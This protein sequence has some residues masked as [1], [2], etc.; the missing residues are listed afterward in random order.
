MV[1]SLFLTIAIR[2]NAGL[3]GVFTRT[4]GTI[5]TFSELA[6]LDSA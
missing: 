3:L 6:M 2:H 5:I 1:R 4:G